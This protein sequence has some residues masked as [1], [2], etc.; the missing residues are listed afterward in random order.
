[1]PLVQVREFIVI[2][3]NDAED[4]ARSHDLERTV[5]HLTRGAPGTTPHVQDI[6]VT[7]P[8]NGLQSILCFNDMGDTEEGNS[9]TRP[10]DTCSGHVARHDMIRMLDTTTARITWLVAW[11]GQEMEL[12][13]CQDSYPDLAKGI[14]HARS[15]YDQKRTVQS[16]WFLETAWALFCSWEVVVFGWTVSAAL[17][18]MGVWLLGQ[19][20]WINSSAN[21]DKRSFLACG[22]F[23]GINA[24]RKSSTVMDPMTKEAS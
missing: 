4:Q 9:K 13:Q 12:G 1:M 7:L 8:G 10:C 23:M 18:V 20:W 11:V 5:D 15:H 21:D 22:S 17:Q 3:F 24:F 16:C 6:N 14:F 2:D 19:K